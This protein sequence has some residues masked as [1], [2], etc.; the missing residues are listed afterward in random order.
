MVESFVFWEIPDLQVV[1]SPV[2]LHIGLKKLAERS[3]SEK[4]KKE[5]VIRAHAVTIG[6]PNKPVERLANAVSILAV[7]NP[8][9]H[10]HES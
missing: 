2:N 10:A 5:C 4:Q 9:L 3:V 8:A 7:V 1:Q 6:R